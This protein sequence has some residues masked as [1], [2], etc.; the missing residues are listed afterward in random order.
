ML[1]GGQTEQIAIFNRISAIERIKYLSG[2]DLRKRNKTYLMLFDLE[3]YQRWYKD[4]PKTH[5]I[6]EE[7][8]QRAATV[9]KDLE[10]D[11]EE[12][13]KNKE[14]PGRVASAFR[15][16]QNR[17][18]SLSVPRTNPKPSRIVS[19]LRWLKKRRLEP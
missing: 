17:P 4:Y 10:K 9:I 14:I 3:M 12:I 15:M 1:R 7:W 8:C 6:D 18:E 2:V 5:K 11:R 13:E 16:H 19:I